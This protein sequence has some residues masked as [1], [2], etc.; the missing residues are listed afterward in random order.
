VV[1]R[2]FALCFAQVKLINAFFSKLLT[3]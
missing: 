2:S 3:L 1:F